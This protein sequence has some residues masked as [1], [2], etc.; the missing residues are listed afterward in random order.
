MILFYHKLTEC[1]TFVSALLVRCYRLSLQFVI[2]NLLMCHGCCTVMVWELVTVY[3]TSLGTVLL[4]S[5]QAGC[6]IG[7]IGLE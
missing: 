7:R 3:K 6:M 4:V 2:H 5:V 1:N